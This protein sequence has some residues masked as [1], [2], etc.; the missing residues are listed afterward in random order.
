MPRPGG[1]KG[2]WHVQEQKGG[3]CGRSSMIKE[4]EWWLGD[5]GRMRR[6]HCMRFEAGER[7]DEA[8][9]NWL[10]FGYLLGSLAQACWEQLEGLMCKKH[11]SF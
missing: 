9:K 1:K 3:H 8:W 7:Q 4:K 5:V 11:Y 2:T 6:S 10:T